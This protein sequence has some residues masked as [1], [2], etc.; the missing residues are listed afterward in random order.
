MLTT[1]SPPQ[2]RFWGCLGYALKEIHWEPGK[3]V[4]GRA[5]T[6]AHRQSAK[7]PTIGP[8]RGD[9]VFCRWCSSISFIVCPID[10]QST[11]L[12]IRIVES[13][14]QHIQQHSPSSKINTHNIQTTTSS[15]IHHN[16]PR[17]PFIPEVLLHE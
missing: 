17:I 5:G 15:S 13:L 11:S 14:F 8:V 10:F 16:P 1:P 6:R 3:S 12:F 2:K 9:F 7:H 4:S